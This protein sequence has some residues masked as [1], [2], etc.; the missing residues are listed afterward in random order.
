MK[1]LDIIFPKKCALCRT[2]IEAGDL[3]EICARELPVMKHICAIDDLP[4]Y[5]NKTLS[6]YCALRYTGTVKKGIVDMKYGDRPHTAKFLGEVTYEILDK[7]DKFS[8]K[9]SEFDYIV[10]VPATAE[11]IKMR[12]YNQ[13][14]LIA[15]G[16]SEKS[17]VSV[18]DGAIIKKSNV[19]S[20]SLLDFAARQKSVAGIYEEALKVS[21]EGKKIILA[22]D[23]LTTGATAIECAKILYKAGAELVVA[24][25]ASTGK[26][27]V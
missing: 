19:K 12:G 17:G 6:A 16:I 14:S 3:C 4:V 2:D 10:P 13:A 8:Y 25:T 9:F 18:L 15:N 21:I 22:D 1:I 5:N 11:K 7:N 20:Q 23:I 24:V 26:K 27:D